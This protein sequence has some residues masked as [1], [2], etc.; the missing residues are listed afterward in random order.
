MASP[1]SLQRLALALLAAMALV[2]ASCDDHEDS[3]SRVINVTL[4]EFKVSPHPSSISAGLVTFHG[5]SVMSG[6]AQ[7]RSLPDS[8]GRHVHAMLFEPAD[9]S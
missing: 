1:R 6:L 8:Y 4:R 9:C 7:L 2:I 5:P 3:G